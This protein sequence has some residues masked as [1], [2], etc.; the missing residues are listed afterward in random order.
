MSD[1]DDERAFHRS[2]RSRGRFFWVRFPHWTDPGWTVACLDDDAAEVIGWEAGV[3][4]RGA[5]I[6]PAIAPPGERG[7]VYETL[8]GLDGYE[9]N[10]AALA[11]CAPDVS[12]MPG[13][14][15]AL[16]AEILRLRGAVLGEAPPGGSVGLRKKG[17]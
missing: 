3:D 11:R 1:S 9:V 2:L 14:I 6:G 16:A 7:E 17:G 10:V 5:E 12:D 15:E 4:L 13:L 8:P